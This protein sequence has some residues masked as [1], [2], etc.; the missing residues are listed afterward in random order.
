[1]TS[2]YFK[3]LLASV[4]AYGFAACHSTAG[5][6]SGADS[7]HSPETN[8][9]TADFKP[10]FSG[11]TRAP[12]VKT[13]TPLTFTVLDTTLNHPWGICNLPDGRLLITE[14]FGTARIETLDGKLDKKITG[15]PPV[16]PKGQGGLLDINIDPN[17]AKNRIVYFDYSELQPD[18]SAVL[19]V[20]KAVLSKDETKI[21]NV[22]IIY[23]ALPTWKG[24]GR[25]LQYGSRIVF[26]KQGNLFVSTGERSDDSARVQAQWLCSSLGK[27][28]H[29]TPDGKPVH[30]ASFP[31]SADAK[32]EIY[33]YG[34]RNPD[35][36]DWNPQTGEL[37]EAEFGPK[38]GDEIN[39]IHAGKNYGWPI[40]TY[41]IEY[42]GVKVGDGITQK[43]G[44]EQPI[45]YWNPSV[46][47]CGITFYNSDSIPEW[48]GNLFVACL[49]GSHIDRLILNGNKVIGEEWL[50]TNEG[51][52]FRSL[53]VGKNGA[54]YAVTDEGRL[55][56]IAKK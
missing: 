42:R 35:G 3:V 29:I 20:A 5:S 11:Q 7:T 12:E 36:L 54:L 38:G 34:F 21:E 50:L 15:F 24:L 30:D 13:Q 40:I 16:I 39:I 44:M 23:R 49:S 43:T 46:S 31:D 48:K 9:P 41:G 14:K 17:F 6:G 53:R 32:P 10:A 4:A 55:Y 37:W 45:Y 19:A 28:I 47:P 52:R 2:Y 18:S 33:A 22:K 8:P 26:D 1:M 25:Y 56:K 51:Q 27:I